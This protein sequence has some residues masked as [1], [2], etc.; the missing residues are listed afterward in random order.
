[1]SRG[2]GGR[3]QR[4]GFRGLGEPQGGGATGAEGKGDQQDGKEGQ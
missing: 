2:T 4:V 1:M 3:W